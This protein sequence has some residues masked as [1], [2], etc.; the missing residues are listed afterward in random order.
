MDIFFLDYDATDWRQTVREVMGRECSPIVTV[1][2]ALTQNVA[3]DSGDVPVRGVL[4]S[5]LHGGLM[6]Y[7]MELIDHYPQIQHWIFCVCGETGV[8]VQKTIRRRFAADMNQRDIYCEFFFDETEK[9]EKL[10]ACLT[11]PPKIGKTCMVISKDTDLAKKAAE[12]IGSYLS[13]WQI[14]P[15]ANPQ[16]PDYSYC[17]AVLVAGSNVNDLCVPCPAGETIKKWFWISVPFQRSPEWRREQLTEL[18][19]SMNIL[20]WNIADYG[21]KTGFSC[22]E[23]EQAKIQIENGKMDPMG[24]LSD[25]QFV[26]WDAYGLPVS[27]RLWTPDNIRTFLRENTFFPSIALR[28]EKKSI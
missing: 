14:V 26:M 15:C 24:L 7:H 9:L 22:L 1:Q 28:L 5:C 2:E 19:Q 10:A 16:D 3:T 8:A 13:N 11:K 4:L 21:P 27:Q 6:A 12:M 20:G 18:K 25:P 23:N 17:D